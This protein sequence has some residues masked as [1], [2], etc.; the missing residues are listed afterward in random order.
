MF[1]KT[2]FFRDASSISTA[3]QS[4]GYLITKNLTPSTNSI[5]SVERSRERRA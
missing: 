1:T 3:L 5:G 4:H 2:F